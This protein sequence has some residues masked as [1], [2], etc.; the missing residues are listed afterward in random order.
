[1]ITI[2]ITGSP[3]LCI[4]KRNLTVPYLIIGS[5]ALN[6]IRTS[7]GHACQQPRDMDVIADF[8]AAQSLLKTANCHIQYP[9]NRGKTLYGKNK[10]GD[11]YEIEIAWPGST[12]EELLNYCNV[13]KENGLYAPLNILYTL[14]M[15]H[16]Y[17]RNSP[18]FMKTMRDIQ[19]M[20]AMGA[21]IP[22]DLHAWFKRREKETYDYSHPNLSVNSGAFFSGDGVHYVYD[23]DSLHEVVAVYGSPVY[24]LYLRD[25]A[26]VQVDKN[27]WLMLNDLTKRTAVYEEACVLALE[28]SLIPYPGKL[29]E[30]RAF[31]I[32]LI[33]VASSITSGWFRQYAW[34]NFDEVIKLYKSLPSYKDKFITALENGQVKH[35]GEK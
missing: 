26:E 34:E 16:R 4:A 7:L 17:L 18:H 6:R 22:E 27:K 31:E 14:K 29:T 5:H 25:G 8:D 3:L 21:T 11:I 35:F 23:H 13:E 30:H 19:E 28:R 10:V 15:S 1:M 9:I 33:K 24:K 20:R 2:T 32:A 12:G